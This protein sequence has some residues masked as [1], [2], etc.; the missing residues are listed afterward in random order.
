MTVRQ[1]VVREFN[2]VQRTGPRQLVQRFPAV[3]VGLG[4]VYAGAFLV[5]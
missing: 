2:R 1:E 5:C 3:S 4:S